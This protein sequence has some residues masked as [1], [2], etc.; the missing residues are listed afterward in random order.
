M[1]SATTSHADPSLPSSFA[2]VFN[3]VTG[4]GNK[5]ETNEPPPQKKVMF[6][7]SKSVVVDDEPFRVTDFDKPMIKIK[8]DDNDNVSSNIALK[9]GSIVIKKLS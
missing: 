3:I 9:G 2:P 1:A 7:E 5:V 4:N 6:D 8:S